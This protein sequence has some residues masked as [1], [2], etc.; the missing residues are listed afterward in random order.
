MKINTIQSTNFEAKTPKKRFIPR[1][2]R[3][4]LASILLKMN[5]EVQTVQ[6][7]DR[8]KLTIVTKLHFK[9]GITFEDERRLTEIVPFEKQM[10]GFS[11]LQI[12][13]KTTLDIDNETGEIIDYKK[14]F[15]KPLFWVLRKAGKILDEIRTNFNL[16]EVVQ[17]ERLTINKLTPEGHKK[18]KIF[19]LQTE[20]E[21][22]EK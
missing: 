5:H 20:K 22:L 8:F 15:Y 10:Q 19:V 9:K 17:K 6:D 18:M 12:G 7:G 13:K 21:R 14:P 1:D 4:S 11:N 2:M 16:S 3:S